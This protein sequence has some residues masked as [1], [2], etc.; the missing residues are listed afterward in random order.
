MNPIEHK[1]QQLASLQKALEES[2]KEVQD[3]ASV[4][5][6][7]VK[8]KNELRSARR[9]SSLAR[10]KIDFARRVT[11]QRM[12]NCLSTSAPDMEEEIISLLNPA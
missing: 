5:E 11:E 1:D 9:S 10:S 8:T 6:Q 2:R 12:S 3:I 7:L 4:R